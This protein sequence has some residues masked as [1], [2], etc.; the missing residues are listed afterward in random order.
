MIFHYLPPFHT[1][2]M[3]LEKKREMPIFVK[4][5]ISNSLT[6]CVILTT[7]RL[8]AASTMLP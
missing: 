4:N 2:T 8:H 6:L 3:G 1:G 5:I 7:R